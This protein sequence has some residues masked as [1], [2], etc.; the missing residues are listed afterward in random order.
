MLINTL[1]ASSQNKRYLDDL[2]QKMAADYESMAKANISGKSDTAGIRRFAKNVIGYGN[3]MVAYLTGKE[4]SAEIE[5]KTYTFTPNKVRLVRQDKRVKTI[6]SEIQTLKNNA[7]A[8]LNGV[9]A[10]RESSATQ[11]NISV[12]PRNSG[13]ASKTRVPAPSVISETVPTDISTQTPPISVPE[14]MSDAETG[15]KTIVKKA[16]NDVADAEPIT[17]NTPVSVGDTF[18]DTK[19]GNT[20]TVVERDA[21]NT[22]VEINTGEKTETREFS[23]NQAEN[24]VTSEQFEKMGATP[25]NITLIRMG[26]F[27]EAYGDEAAEIANKLNLA[28]ASKTING[29]RVQMVGFP[30]SSLDNYKSALGSGY[31]LAV[32]NQNM[33]AG[34]TADAE[35]AENSA[36]DKSMYDIMGEFGLTYDEQ[37]AILEYKSSGSYMFSSKLRDGKQLTAEQLKK[38][39]H[40]NLAIDKFPKYSGIAYRNIG[41]ATQDEFDAF[42]DEHSGKHLITYPAFTSVSKDINGYAVNAPYSAHYEIE[43][44]NGGDV[45]QVGIEAEREVLFKTDTTFD[46]T[47]VKNTGNSIFIKMKEVSEN[48]K[49]KFNGILEERGKQP[50]VQ[51]P[52]SGL[53]NSGIAEE[54]SGASDIIRGR[55]SAYDEVY[56]GASKR[57]GGRIGSGSGPQDLGSHAE[58]RND[59]ER[60]RPLS[61]IRDNAEAT[62]TDKCELIATKHTATGDNI[63]VVSLKD[64]LSPDEYKDLRE[65]VKAVGGY[66]SRFAK[67]PDGKAIPGFVFKTEPTAKELDVFNDF[68]GYTEETTPAENKSGIKEIDVNTLLGA[69]ENANPGDKIKLSDYE[70]Q[71]STERALNNQPESDMMEEN[72]DKDGAENAES[73]SEVLDR[74]SESDGGRLYTG[75][76]KSAVEAGIEGVGDT[77]RDYSGEGLQESVGADGS[78]PDGRNDRERVHGTDDTA[79]APSERAGNSAKITDNAPGNIETQVKTVEKKRTS[80]KGNF[81]ITDDIAAEFDNAP[82]SAKDN[83]EAIELLLAPED[84]GRAAAAEEKKTLAKYKGW[85]GI[86]TR[87]IPYELSSRFSELFDWEQRKAMQS[88][89]NNAFFIPTK[90]YRRNVC[91][92]EANV[93]QGR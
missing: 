79:N 6:I 78:R 55:S 38:K 83:I 2:Y 63:W 43:C 1:K 80:N 82:P 70:K 88:S 30:V 5:R 90:V 35:A 21:E 31:K 24:L 44:V 12:L 64:R 61:G 49:G 8:V 33:A 93:I 86:D 36:V 68:F 19:I 39:E 20:I 56:N 46:F 3:A 69:A 29:E 85:G 26:D 37:R 53:K 14:A 16:V 7:N 40:L 73:Q 71:N 92:T 13:A 32:S 47:I 34:A 28:L 58:A 59:S 48:G 18:K 51:K 89:Q 4:F 41:F 17:N 62:L 75:T 74:K 60:E 22:T 65:K 81:V 42:V 11:E 50:E 25:K 77:S 23:N 9:S 52:G 72:T 84:E 91:R 66:Y 45:S 76:S 54:I 87:R 27:Y 15:T 67:T 10:P 57:N